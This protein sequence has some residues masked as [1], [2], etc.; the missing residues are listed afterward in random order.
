[1]NHHHLTK[2]DRHVI[3]WGIIATAAAIP[4]G[5]VSAVVSTLIGAVLAIL[6]WMAFR[7][8]V[9]R[10]ATSGNRLGFGLSLGIKS[11]AILGIITILVVLLPLNPVAL[12]CGFSALFLGIVSYTFKQALDKGAAAL[13]KDL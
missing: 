13:K 7:F 11:I 12:T 5:G 2:I 4:I 8:I 1:M 9:L 3:F 10:M 6:N